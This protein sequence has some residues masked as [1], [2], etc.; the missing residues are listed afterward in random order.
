MA[1]TVLKTEQDKADIDPLVDK[2]Y[3]AQETHS[4]VIMINNIH[5][6][7]SQTT[8]TQDF[9]DGSF[10]AG[11]VWWTLGTRFDISKQFLSLFNETEQENVF[12]DR[13]GQDQR[14]SP[15]ELNSG[16]T[17][18]KYFPFEYPGNA[19]LTENFA[20][21]LDANDIIQTD[22]MT[23]AQE[24]LVDYPD[25]TDPRLNMSVRNQLHLFLKSSYGQ[26]LAVDLKT[27]KL[28]QIDGTHDQPLRE[29]GL[30]KI[31]KPYKAPKFLY[32]DYN[33]PGEVKLY[34]VTFLPNYVKDETGNIVTKNVRGKTYPVYAFQQI[35][36][37]DWTQTCMYR[38][39]AREILVGGGK[40]Y[41]LT[42]E[43]DGPSQRECENRL[44]QSID[45]AETNILSRLDN[46][47]KSLTE[48][49]K[50]LGYHDPTTVRRTSGVVATPGKDTLRNF[51]ENNQNIVDWWKANIGNID[52]S[53]TME[54]SRLWRN[55]FP[56]T[57]P[58]LFRFKVKDEGSKVEFDY[59]RY[60]RSS[61]NIM[62]TYMPFA[63]TKSTGGDNKIDTWLNPQQIRGLNI[64]QWSQDFLL[65]D[66]DKTNEDLALKNQNALKSNLNYIFDF[67]SFHDSKRMSYARVPINIIAYFA[68]GMMK[69]K[70][71]TEVRFEDF[72]KEFNNADPQLVTSK[73]VEYAQNFWATATVADVY[74]IRYRI[75]VMSE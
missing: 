2:I 44:F 54:R 49:N 21:E 26:F 34:L 13:N 9:K 39:C 42:R 43:D 16:K 56:D 14:P 36:D 73:L 50:R 69:T 63:L 65:S 51:F 6:S 7:E 68:N 41:D 71:G 24:I 17:T 48:V 35:G 4:S 38:V 45:Q 46:M 57:W 19:R 66:T 74:K 15:Q 59:D 75:Y 40:P 70:E 67:S 30:W 12:I 1:F 23:D 32:I 62:S 58:G 60:G 8:T 31:S 10:Q 29:F 28:F 47:A 33:I 64:P 37:L 20:F 25:P 55:R 11:T 53:T 22:L 5:Y 52:N 61:L 72:V 18:Y 27:H 3:T